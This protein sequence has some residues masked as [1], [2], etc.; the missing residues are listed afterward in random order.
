MFVN[1]NILLLFRFPDSHL[2]DVLFGI[3]RNKHIKI[4]QSV[5]SLSQQVQKKTKKKKN[6][7]NKAKYIVR[8]WAYRCLTEARML[9]YYKPE[10]HSTAAFYLHLSR[11]PHQKQ[12]RPKK[13]TPPNPKTNS[14][15]HPCTHAST[16]P[17]MK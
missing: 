14:S 4:N 10:K 5:L 12:L 15:A 2:S 6:C 3:F 17:R 13:S 8:M 11:N 16:F 7:Q 1:I 9:Q